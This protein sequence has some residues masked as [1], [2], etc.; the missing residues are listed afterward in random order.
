MDR[1]YPKNFVMWRPQF[2][3]LLI[4][5]EV[6]Y[7]TAGYA[8]DTIKRDGSYRS[9][10]LEDTDC[11]ADFQCHTNRNECL[12]P[13]WKNPYQAMFYDSKFDK[14]FSPAKKL[15][16]KND[17]GLWKMECVPYA[18]CAP[19]NIKEVSQI[20]G[21]CECLP[22]FEM[23]DGHLCEPA[24]VLK[25]GNHMPMIALERK[26][27]DDSLLPIE[28]DMQGG[29]SSL[30]KDSDAVPVQPNSDPKNGITASRIA[31]SI[32]DPNGN[33]EVVKAHLDRHAEFSTAHFMR[34]C[35]TLVITFLGVQLLL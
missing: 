13:L 34:S 15:C 26:K 14:C 31:T 21:L 35:V 28:Q 17:D 27:V 33:I 10:C 16:T 1:F 12:C 30:D 18:H 11:R 22:S 9:F 2:V 23:T 7:D 4:F 19:H 6:I 8:T 24:M 25:V 29:R 5:L 32:E 3:L 20:F